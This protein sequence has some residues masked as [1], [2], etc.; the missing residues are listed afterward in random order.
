MLGD[1]RFCLRSFRKSPGFVAIA[2]LVLA[3]GIG[4]NTAIF[5]VVNGALLH[6]LPYPDSERIVMLWEKNPLLGD[7]LAERVPVNLANFFA[8]RKDSKSF[9]VMAV[10]EQQTFTLTGGDKPE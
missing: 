3:L 6:A 1:L 7:L 10:Y 8:W 4:A 2:I 5:S 9:D